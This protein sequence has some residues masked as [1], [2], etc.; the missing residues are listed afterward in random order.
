MKKSELRSVL[1]ALGR[2]IEG[3]Y[4]KANFDESQ[5]GYIAH[6][7]VR[8]FHDLDGLNVAEL[9]QL[10]E[11]EI[12]WGNV[13]VASAFSNFEI[14]PFRSRHFYLQILVWTN[15]TT[16]IHQHSFSGAFRVLTGSSIHGMYSFER[17]TVVNS[18]F[19]IGRVSV[20]KVDALGVGE[21]TIISC[22]ASFIHSVFHSEFPS[23]TLLART[24]H[25]PWASPQFMYRPPFFAF[26]PF[27]LNTWAENVKK[28]VRVIESDGERQSAVL[29]LCGS[30]PKDLVAYLYGFLCSQA[31][32]KEALDKGLLNRFS[33]QFFE[34]LTEVR[35]VS[36]ASELGIRLRKDIRNAKLA[37]FL[38]VLLLSKDFAS[39]KDAL[40]RLQIARKESLESSIWDMVA[41][42]V[43]LPSFPV[44]VDAARLQ[45]ILREIFFSTDVVDALS[46]LGSKYDLDADT[47]G[48]I[49]FLHESLRREPLFYK[50]TL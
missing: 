44:D 7:T 28:C 39:L 40:L 48:D 29:K 19:H 4:S 37:E 13:G 25:E 27:Q 33:S 1:S 12:R 21:T 5:F 17:E 15:A 20:A 45:P 36:V 38:G 32:D 31:V 49:K 2:E 35:E 18:R 16:S 43:A 26:D 34:Q 42:L 23:V 8:K 22:G 24:Y 50:L 46:M 11:H 30:L 6:E 10:L 9:V 14:V 41:K 47:V 3:N